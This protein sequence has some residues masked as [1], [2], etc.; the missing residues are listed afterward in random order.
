MNE[1]ITK[2]LSELTNEGMNEINYWLNI[3]MNEFLNKILIELM[4]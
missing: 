2:V 3:G 1:F 4:N